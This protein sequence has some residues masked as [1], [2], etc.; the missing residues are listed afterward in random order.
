MAT[1]VQRRSVDKR[2]QQRFRLR[3]SAEGKKPVTAYISETAQRILNEQK[4]KTGESHSEIVERAILNLKP[5]LVRRKT[6]PALYKR[7]KE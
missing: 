3:K 7:K 2:R 6:K 4:E 1:L 5:K